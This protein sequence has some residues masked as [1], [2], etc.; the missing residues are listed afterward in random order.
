LLRSVLDSPGQPIDPATRHF[1]EP[2]FATDFSRV[3]VH[4]GPTADAAARSIGARAFTHG[5][6]VVLGRGQGRMETAEGRRLMAHEL[7]HVAQQRGIVSRSSK[8]PV[9]TTDAPEEREAEAAEG[10]IDAETGMDPSV[11]RPIISKME[12]AFEM[13]FDGVRLRTDA[14]A[15]RRAKDLR[16][17]AFTDGVEIVFASG[18]CAPGTREG[19]HTIAHEFAHVAQSRGGNGGQ[20][21]PITYPGGMIRASSAIGESALQVEAE[22]DYAADRVLAGEKPLVRRVDLTLAARSAEA[23]G[24][25]GS[26]AEGTFNVTQISSGFAYEFHSKDVL[27]WNDADPLAR[28]FRMYFKDV[29]HTSD[30]VANEYLGAQGSS[31]KTHRD[32]MGLEGGVDVKE[33]AK[34]D[35]KF[36]I[37]ITNS[38]HADVLNWMGQHH[39]NLK[40]SPPPTGTRALGGPGGLGDERKQRLEGELGGGGPITSGTLVTDTR[41]LYSYF[42][43]NFPTHDVFAKDL[44]LLEDLLQFLGN[45]PAER[46]TLPPLPGKSQAPIDRAPWTTFLDHWHAFIT[47]RKKQ[48]GGDD[49]ATDPT[50]VDQKSG[51][52]G[53]VKDGQE[54][55]IVQF[56]P[57]A[58]IEIGTKETQLVLGSKLKLKVVFD[59][60]S[61]GNYTINFL[62]NHA[63]FDWSLKARGTEFAT[64][65]LLGGL[66]AI[67]YEPELPKLGPL[68]IFVRVSSPYFKDG[69]TPTI[70]KGGMEVV[71]EAQRGKDVFEA[72]L[73]NPNDEKSPFVRDDQG[74]LQLKPGQGPLSVDRE[75]E[76]IRFNLGAVAEL[77][78][79]GKLNADQAKTLRESFNKQLEELDKIKP[80]EGNKKSYVIRG[81]FV[82]RENSEHIPLKV[83]LVLLRRD[84]TPPT[85]NYE[86]RGEDFTLDP[87]NPNYQPGEAHVPSDGPKPES[88]KYAQAEVQALEAMRIH[89]NSFNDYPDGKV[90]LAV[91]LHETGAIIELDPI[92]THG[93]RKT[94]KSALG[95]AAGAGGLALLVSSPF[96]GGATVPVAI[97]LLETAVVAAGTASI[98]LQLQDRYEQENGLVVD[99]R[100]GL[101]LFQL[102]ATVGGFGGFSSVIRS[103]STVTRGLYVGTLAGLNVGSAYLIGVEAREQILL[104]QGRYEL[105]VKEEPAREPEFARARDEAVAQI[106]G[107]AAVNGTFMLVSAAGVAHGLVAAKAH[108]TGESY[109]IREEIRDL[110]GTA[111]HDAA[112]I[113]ERLTTDKM[114]TNDERAF[115]NETLRTTK[116]GA[117]AKPATLEPDGKTAAPPNGHDR[118]LTPNAEPPASAVSQRPPVPEMKNP[119]LVR[120]VND[121]TLDLF[122]RRPELP[123]LLDE[124]PDAAK[125]FKR[126]NTPC[127]KD[128]LER[129]QLEKVNEFLKDAGELD[130]RFDEG[131]LRETL[132]SAKDQQ[133]LNK[134]IDGLEKQLEKVREDRALKLERDQQD[135]ADPIG[136]EH[137]AETGGPADPRIAPEGTIEESLHKSKVRTSFQAGNEGGKA[138]ATR[139][140]IKIDAWNNPRAHVGDYGRGIDAV[141]RRGADRII[142]EWKGESS[143]LREPDQM[144][145]SWVGRKIAQL[146]FERDR[147][148]QDLLA[149]ARNGRLKGRVY[150][151]KIEGGGQLSAKLDGIELDY[152]R[153][154]VEAAYNRELKR[155]WDAVAK[156]KVPRY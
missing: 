101:D 123:T 48:A 69:A 72:T 29:Y 65:P 61:P 75:R 119:E 17:L 28:I 3:R 120:G 55:G 112:S 52:Q 67:E 5:S 9:G 148:A 41:K 116:E 8:I 31:G 136:A 113:R 49:K 90:R 154:D 63:S 77:E 19:L 57:H 125:V 153:S 118:T 130:V 131:L 97:V 103:A 6:D 142:L 104:A 95:I 53:G 98:A 2:R 86:I 128:F 58:D 100:L 44:A 117:I 70:Y 68:E 59:Q 99:R 84:K 150:K 34:Q 92:E 27:K 141:G 114:L 89:W 109:T 32:E 80:F 78:K 20:S 111:A 121:E 79:Q 137:R 127:F 26:V 134:L 140:G 13:P 135:L 85:L 24:S 12:S 33:L 30:N 36:V 155:L 4:T 152:P 105:H 144:K 115:L 81:T 122:Q 15:D 106:L 96:T 54:G 91:Q 22:A 145:S 23:G 110:A 42:F 124:F 62:P 60:S 39:P 74:R 10:L 73:V 51:S 143:E 107:S 93:K 56:E 18:A 76:S 102:V 45:Q 149:A 133:Q 151:T 66:G 108:P 138:Q 146:E 83:F 25:R 7:T 129:D 87:S 156:G 126:C 46:G 50:K 21:G 139:D 38:L 43:K 14:E 71:S 64:G 94:V 88:Q 11:S 132:Y 1:F 16:A 37:Y 35:P 40:P 82:S 47:R 147:I